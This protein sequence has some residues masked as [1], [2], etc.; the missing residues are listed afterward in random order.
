MNHQFF[1][2]G[3][4]LNINTD[5]NTGYNFWHIKRTQYYK[6]HSHQPLWAKSS[7]INTAVFLSVKLYCSSFQYKAVGGS[8]LTAWIITWK[9]STDLLRM[10]HQMLYVFVS[11]FIFVHRWKFSKSNIEGKH[12]H[13]GNVS[14][15]GFK[16]KMTEFM[17]LDQI[18]SWTTERTCGK[19]CFLVAHMTS[20]T[21]ICAAHQLDDTCSVW[22]TAAPG[23]E[24]Q[25]RK[26][27]TRSGCICGAAVDWGAGLPRQH[28]QSFSWQA[29]PEWCKSFSVD[30]L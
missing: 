15:S 8:G 5:Q 13:F 3:I 12:K 25:H 10:S 6:V 27:I 21:S 18:W 22:L 1:Q 19:S 23:R 29:Q 2:W 20:E 14:K 9:F 30:C 17:F 26:L 28:P 4:L 16:L 7:T 24:A 11:H